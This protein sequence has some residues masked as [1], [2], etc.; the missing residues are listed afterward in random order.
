MSE[1][2]KPYPRPP[3][4]EAVIELRFK[5]RFAVRDMERMRDQFK[6]EFPRVE[7][8][9]DVKVN[10]VADGNAAAAAEQSGFRLTSTDAK[11]LVLL[12]ARNIVT[13]R[14]AP[15]LGWDQLFG[16]TLENFA[17]VTK[18]VGRPP[19]D[20]LGVRF[21]NRIDL[22][23][24]MIEGRDPAELFNVG[25]ALPKDLGSSLGQ[26]SMSAR[27]VEKETGCK[28]RI[29]SSI[30]APALIDHVSISLDIDAYLE[31]DI[32][33]RPEEIW[34]ELAKLRQA[35]NRVFES[36]ITGQV[37]ELFR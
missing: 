11:S 18:I 3:I 36:C 23:S 28:L 10:V 33:M 6:R 16:K 24:K 5:E 12:F 35:K 32:P 27:I 13:S 1:A 31:G 17:V 19:L 14:L 20:R 7:A 37:R 29:Q 4:T 8:T 2:G 9:Y 25:V 15:Y 22:P 34:A 30:V 21:I 26:Y